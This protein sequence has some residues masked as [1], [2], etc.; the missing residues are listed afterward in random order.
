MQDARIDEA[1]AIML[2]FARRTGL[3]SERSPR[4]YLW[5]DAFAVC[6]FL[7][8]A[9]A[10]GERRYFDLGVRLIAQVHQV[11]GRHREDDSCR[12]WISGLG[13]RE[14]EEHPTRG[15]LRIGKPLPE[16][17]EGEPLDEMLE[18]ERDGQYFHYL[19]RWMHALDQAS[20]FLGDTR[21]K[22]WACELAA[23]AHEAFTY[24]PAGGGAPRMYWK[25]SV[26]LDRP[27]VSSMGQH[28]PLDG[29][30]TALQLRAGAAAMPSAADPDLTAAI[31]RYAEMI[32]R[33][34]LTSPDPL[35]IGGLLIDAHR[36][37]QLL[38][39]GLEASEDLLARVLRAA[40][41]G[42]EHYARSRQG[43]APA[44][45][46]LAFRELG[47]ALGLEAVEGISRLLDQEQ[48]VVNA[49]VRSELVEL[50]RQATL[51]AEIESFWRDPANQKAETWSGHLDINAV[52]L[53]TC[54][55]PGGF[56]ALGS[57]RLGGNEI[58]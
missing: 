42:V 50:R 17:A 25:M 14:G 53:A 46:R 31:R 58:R 12:G 15:G 16:R 32:E 49:S 47:L 41:T 2:D 48:I 10:T 29:Y 8:L 22:V 45:Q 26:D 6:N 35:G 40:R 1:G 39:Q 13:D 44:A 54:L 57:R 37:A 52:M 24:M 9:S 36:I 34:D 20:R 21:Y 30:V 18:W 3:D 27:L 28:D 38:E 19:T 23:A 5:T 7:G 33:L 43:R 51:G 4:R 11:L 55:V 56:L